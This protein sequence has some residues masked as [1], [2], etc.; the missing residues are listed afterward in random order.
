MCM[1]GDFL[2]L[3]GSVVVNDQAPYWADANLCCLFLHMLMFCLKI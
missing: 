3:V 2:R 1:D